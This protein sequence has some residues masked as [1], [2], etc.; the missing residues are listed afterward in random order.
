MH[1][2]SALEYFLSFVIS[3]KEEH[4]LFFIKRTRPKRRIVI[5]I[6]KHE[7]TQTMLCDIKFFRIVKRI[8]YTA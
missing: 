6:D 1:Q 7:I 5:T 3:T 8:G 4:I 2:M